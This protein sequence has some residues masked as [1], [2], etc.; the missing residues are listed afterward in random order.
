MLGMLN[1]FPLTPIQWDLC[2]QGGLLCA[3]SHV[4][5]ERRSG[6]V[7]SRLWES[8]CI[9]VFPLSSD[10][11]IPRMPAYPGCLLLPC[12]LNYISVYF[13]K[14]H[15]SCATLPSAP[16]A[17]VGGDQTWLIVTFLLLQVRLHSAA[18][19]EVLQQDWY[20]VILFDSPLFIPLCSNTQHQDTIHVSAGFWLEVRNVHELLMHCGSQSER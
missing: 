7:A 16:T 17:L 4:L 2:Q 14:G 10:R 5:C 11:R 1:C 13:Q 9:T 19:D 6:S 12:F 15:F 8:R 3:L 20:A 18:C